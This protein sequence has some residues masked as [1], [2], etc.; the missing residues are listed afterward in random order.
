MTEPERAQEIIRVQAEGIRLLK[1]A[2]CL[3][4]EI[5]RPLTLNDELAD[6]G[7]DIRGLGTGAPG[8]SPDCIIR[9]RSMQI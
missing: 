5:A 1:K 6:R 3:F 8:Q 9:V 7:S 2:L 4:N